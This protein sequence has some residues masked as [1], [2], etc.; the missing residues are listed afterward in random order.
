MKRPPTSSTPRT[1]WWPSA[2]S[3]RKAPTHVLLIPRE[4]IDSAAE[5]TTSEAGMLGEL[6][7]VAAHLAKAERIDRTGWRLV[8]NVGPGRRTECLPPALSPAGRAHDGLAARLT[9]RTSRRVAP[10][11]LGISGA[12]LRPRLRQ[13]TRNPI[14]G[15]QDEPHHHHEVKILV[16]DHQP[17]VALVGQADELLKL[18][19]RAFDARIVVRGN[20]ITIT[21]PSGEV[22][23]A[24][25]LFEEL[26]A[27]LE[28]GH[29][30][31]TD[32]LGHTIDMIKEDEARPHAG[33]RRHAADRS[34]QDAPPEDVR[35]EA[36]R[37]RHPQGR[38]SRSASVRP[39]PARPTWRSPRRSRRSRTG[40]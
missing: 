35:T 12:A 13:S 39:G 20:E 5:L 26:L 24:A 37:R 23:R 2:T 18:V 25:L 29:D 16:P 17:M 6:F 31:S 7:V 4:H 11:I 40:T 9:A 32:S 27:L 28:Q 3:T 10:G 30:L 1:R 19:E 34:R 33:L 36:L 21:G 15:S 8:T 14:G 38:R 22:E